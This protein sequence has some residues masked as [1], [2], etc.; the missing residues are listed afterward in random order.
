MACE[1]A[2]PEEQ[3]FD[4]VCH[5]SVEIVEEAVDESSADND[6]DHEGVGEVGGAFRVFTF[7]AIPPPQGHVSDGESE[8]KED[9]VIS[10]F[11]TSDANECGVPVPDEEAKGPEKIS[12]NKPP[13]RQCGGLSEADGK[14]VFCREVPTVDSAQNLG[15]KGTWGNNLQHFASFAYQF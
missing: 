9:A 5:V 10:N 2:F 1:S 14:E 4:G 3:D 12:H 11:K 7:V 15:A 8:G 6:A 13:N